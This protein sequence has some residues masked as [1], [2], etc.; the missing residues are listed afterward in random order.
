VS[1]HCYPT[2]QFCVALVLAAT[3]L[4]VAV[5]IVVREHRAVVARISGRLNG[6]E[7]TS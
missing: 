6:H 3:G 2:E 1:P 5:G 4:A 7:A